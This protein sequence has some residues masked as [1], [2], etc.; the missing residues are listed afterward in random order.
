MKKK[1]KLKEA[2]NTIE[3]LKDEV[4]L[5]QEKQLEEE[6]QRISEELHDGILGKLF[7]TRLNL[8]FF[9][10]KN[11]QNKENYQKFLNELKDIEN[12]IREVSHKLKINISNPNIGFEDILKK[13]IKDKSSISNFHHSLKVDP[14]IKWQNFNEVNKV[15]LYRILQE[16]LQNIIKHSRAKNVEIL[17][18]KIENNLEII[19]EDNGIGFK[20]TTQKNGIGINNINSRVKR[21][22]GKIIINSE[23]NMGTHIQIFIPYF[24]KEFI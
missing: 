10:V 14:K 1:N 7:G 23:P 8:G 20:T 9:D 2:L 22:N 24:E 19:I 4:F 17:I 15:N 16:A 6:R 21:L 13:L 18:S 5:S 11:E 3:K 12:E